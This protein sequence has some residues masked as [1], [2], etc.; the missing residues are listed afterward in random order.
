MAVLRAA[1]GLDRDDALDLDLGAAPAH[2]DLVRELQRGGQVLVGQ[3]QHLEH[4]RLVEA[5]A[6]AEDLGA[7]AVKDR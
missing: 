6:V 4:A 7:G 3:R 2:A 5:G 1:A